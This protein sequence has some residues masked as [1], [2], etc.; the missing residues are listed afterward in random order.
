MKVKKLAIADMWSYGGPGKTVLGEFGQVNVIIG[1]NNAGKSNLIKTLKWAQST[2][3]LTVEEKKMYKLVPNWIHNPGAFKRDKTPH[4]QCTFSITVQDWPTKNLP[5]WISR[6]QSLGDEGRL[7]VFFTI[8]LEGEDP[9]YQVIEDFTWE[10]DTKAMELIEKN[11]TNSYLLIETLLPLAREVVAN[12]IVVLDGWRQLS[13]RIKAD[14]NYVECIDKLRR[15]PDAAQRDSELYRNIRGFFQELTGIQA[16]ELYPREDEA[17]FNITIAD[18]TMPLSQYGDGIRHLLMVSIKAAMNPGGVF[19]VEEPETHLHP[20]FQRHLLWFLADRIRSQVFVT[21]HS[22]V[23]L[24]SRKTDCILR[25]TNEASSR[26]EVVETLSDYYDV[27]D[28]IGA[29]P[30]DIL[31]AN[32]VIWVEGPSDRILIRHALTVVDPELHEGL[33]FQ[34]ICY[35]GALRKYCTFDEKSGALVNLMRL[36]R[37]VA[38]VCDR[39]GNSSDAQINAEKERLK[40]ECDEANGFCWVTQGR[41]IENYLSDSVLG[42]A[43][44]DV[45]SISDLSLKLSENQRLD[46]V[47]KGLGRRLNI[48]RSKWIHY[49][50]HKPEI[51]SRIVKSIT[52]K[53]DLDRLDFRTRL[54]ALAKFIRKHNTLNV[55]SSVM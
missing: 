9:F 29:R 24:D 50:Q 13:D 21:T 1:K 45:L 12:K 47:L 51:M 17:D 36:G 18:K 23:F 38:M 16:I 8:S 54:E 39:D 33:H 46:D 34:I 10:N 27:L 2:V 49:A 48:K 15:S 26:V 52:E 41:E 31:Q 3:L 19:L 11:S 4:L 28:D 30:S 22:S 40:K 55:N 43:F 6:L 14:E 37:K 25:I 35:G 5:K 20:H 7:N 32:V 42:R 44:Q 53:A